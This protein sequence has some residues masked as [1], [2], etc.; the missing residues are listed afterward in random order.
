MRMH[1][2]NFLVNRH[3][4]IR[5]RY[6]RVH[7]NGGGLRKL[8]SYVYLLCMN[9]GYYFLFCRFLS[10]P[11]AV[12]VYEEKRLSLEPE[13]AVCDR[14]K[15]NVEYFVDRLSK[16]DLISFDIFDTL[17]FR[18]FSEPADLFFFLG[19]QLE[20]PD[21][22]RI[23]MEQESLARRDALAQCGHCEVTLSHIWKRME[24]E[25]GIPA[26]SGM[27]LEM[28]LEMDF[29][30]ANPFM[31]QVFEALRRM[32]KKMIVVSDM[33]LPRD[34]L[35]ALLEKNG[36]GGIEKLY[37][38]CEYGKSKADGALFELIKG[39][40]PGTTV[41]HVGDNEHSD[42]KMAKK[43]GFESLFYP[44]VN[45][46]A[47]LLRPYDMSPVI[48]GAYRGIVN[49]HLYQGNMSYSREYE[50]GF[51]YGGLFVLGYCQ[52][53]HEYC[54]NEK[55]DRLLFL[56]RDGDILKQVYDQLYPE[57]ETSY[58][59][60]SR[61]A[62]VKLMAEFDRYDYF[63]RYLYHKVNQG[64]TVG[65]ALRSMELETVVRPAF[66][67]SDELTDR[68]VGMLKELLLEHFDTICAVYREQRRAAKAYFERELAGA[69]RAAAVDIGW[70]G[71]G[72]LSLSYLVEQVW[73]MPCKV[74]GVVAGTNTVHSGE[75]D[76]SEFFLQR[77]KL[78][79]FLFSQAHNRDVMKK[80]D[81][82]KD[83]NVYWELLLSSASRQFLG[84]QCGAGSHGKS[85]HLEKGTG[86]YLE[87]GREA[88]LR[89][90]REDANQEGIREIQ[91]G[92]LDFVFD[93]REHFETVPY[94]LRISGRDACAPMLAAAG[95]KERYLRAMAERFTLEKGI[96]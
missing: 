81:P 58:V 78:V 64:V 86:I 50:Y 90:G 65:E 11:Q 56:S 88:M 84:F 19:G 79:S 31:L 66:S 26:D 51:V 28:A 52:F 42:K 27:E 17:I 14:E 53:I 4:G 39:E 29:C 68:N 16:Y 40:Y 70:A 92:I 25:T 7:D 80:H 2:Y 49:N 24:R 21:I 8:I 46:M 82:N 1:I 71:S 33:Y 9:F 12:E 61:A 57:D 75:P 5:S 63:R 35:E 3:S 45:R 15:L 95:Q 32:G 47:V 72:A 67:L 87:D 43:N 30:Y 94:M 23:R 36:Y 13:S 89:F 93:Y 76:A 59:Y 91:K 69:A 37:V 44:N 96:S 73:R 55:I 6:H 38:S 54:V 20:R 41:I 74:T 77:G 85:C 60:W 18:P 34:F 10:Q 22:R 48:G 62:A 83:Y